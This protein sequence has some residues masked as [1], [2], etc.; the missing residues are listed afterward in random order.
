MKK[1]LVLSLFIILLV[2]AGAAL[3]WSASTRAQTV[4]VAVVE[5]AF[6]G[7]LLVFLLASRL[8]GNPWLA[9]AAV[10]T[11]GVSAAVYVVTRHPTVAILAAMGVVLAG[12]LSLRAMKYNRLTR[13]TEQLPEVLNMISRSL[14]AGHSLTNAVELVGEVE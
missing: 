12:Y 7:V 8:G 10:A 11:V 13:F 5:M 1:V 2:V 3:Y 6:V 4:R 9:F 14:R